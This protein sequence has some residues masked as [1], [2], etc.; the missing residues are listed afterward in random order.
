MF[1]PIKKLHALYNLHQ[2]LPFI[3]AYCK[4]RMI[5]LLA[6]IFGLCQCM[7]VCLSVC[8]DLEIIFPFV[9]VRDT[10]LKTHTGILD[11][12]TSLNA[13]PSFDKRS[14]LTTTLHPERLMYSNSGKKV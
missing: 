5:Y 6:V 12:A 14:L 8:R 13:P 2:L 11:I 3:K 10:D 1:M 7:S 4:M 9:I